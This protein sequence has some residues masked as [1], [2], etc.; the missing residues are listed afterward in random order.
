[1]D[2]IPL[3]ANMILFVVN[4]EHLAC[5]HD[6]IVD[7]VPLDCEDDFVLDLVSQACVDDLQWTQYS[8]VA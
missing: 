4:P 5:E 6:I 2:T 8:W 1:M 3:S 7:S